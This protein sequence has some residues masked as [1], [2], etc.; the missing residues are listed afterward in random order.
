[1]NSVSAAQ[2]PIVEPIAPDNSMADITNLFYNLQ[3]SAPAHS[4]ASCS[5]PQS[6]T[7]TPCKFAK[8]DDRCLSPGDADRCRRYILD[9]SKL[10]LTGT[11]GGSFC[12]DVYSGYLDQTAVAV[13]RLRPHLAGSHST[14]AL[15]D[16]MN[17]IS[18]M[19]RYATPSRPHLSVL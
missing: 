4:Q 10:R 5:S 2:L 11:I 7:K 1:M 15:N 9:P 18:F 3:N 16:L 17:E 14:T 13:K 12:C 19:S 6:R 8:L